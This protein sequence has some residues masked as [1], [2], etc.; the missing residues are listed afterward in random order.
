MLQNEA[1]LLQEITLYLQDAFQ[2]LGAIKNTR[3]MKTGT[4]GWCPQLAIRLAATFASG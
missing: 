1:T 4:S 2:N 3:N